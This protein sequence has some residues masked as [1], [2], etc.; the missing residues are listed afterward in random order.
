MSFVR[1]MR[2]TK[3]SRTSLALKLCTVTWRQA[4]STAF[5]CGSEPRQEVLVSRKS[6]GSRELTGGNPM[7]V[8]E[9][10][11]RKNV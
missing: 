11:T 2:D 5:G 7:C 4:S 10:L 3:M 1:G 8:N 9:G 6:F